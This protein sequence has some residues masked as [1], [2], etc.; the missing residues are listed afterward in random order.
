MLAENSRASDV[1][2]MWVIML[3]SA[4][5]GILLVA[6][7]NGLERLLTPWR[8]SSQVVAVPTKE[9]RLATRG[10]VRS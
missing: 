2:A 7:V 1:V 10:E 6:L 4:V 9:T 5:L 3:S 8:R